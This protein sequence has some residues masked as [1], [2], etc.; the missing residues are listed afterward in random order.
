MPEHSDLLTVQVLQVALSARYDLKIWY[1]PENRK[2]EPRI[3]LSDYGGIR[4]E[5]CGVEGR[6]HTRRQ[7]LKN[8]NDI[9]AFW[10]YERGWVVFYF[11]WPFSA[12]ASL[13]KQWHKKKKKMWS[14]TAHER[15]YLFTAVQSWAFAPKLHDFSTTEHVRWAELLEALFT[16]DADHVSTAAPIET[17]HQP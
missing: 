11:S 3:I 1:E 13:H 4:V 7:M 9:T 12:H 14:L 16:F 8:N 2:M 17:F 5:P 6:L 15:M 10:N